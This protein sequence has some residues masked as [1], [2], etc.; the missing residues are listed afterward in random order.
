[1]SSSP[2]EQVFGVLLEQAHTVAPRALGALVAQQA[3]V[4][5]ATDVVIYLQ[6]YEQVLL[7]PL[8]APG[9]E[10][11]RPEPIDSSVAGRVFAHNLS[12][13]VPAPGGVRLY[14]PLLDGTD[15]VGALGLTLC[16]LDDEQ[17][18]MWSQFASLVSDLI[19]TKGNYSDVFVLARRSRP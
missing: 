14:V 1:M 15:R 17:R 16:C 9:S 12:V 13:E 10:H 2:V 11:L 4:L 8:G 6:D 5:G 19:V 7:I 3:A 18:R